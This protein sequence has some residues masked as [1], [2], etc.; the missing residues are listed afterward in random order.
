[1]ALPHQIEKKYGGS[2]AD[3]STNFWP[4]IIPSSNYGHD[5]SLVENFIHASSYMGSG[6]ETM[7]KDISKV[8]E[9]EPLPTDRCNISDDESM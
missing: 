7:K 6:L 4:A 3:I 9:F 2:A 1:M 8:K 5:K